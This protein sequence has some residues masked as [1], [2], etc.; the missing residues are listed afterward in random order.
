[1]SNFCESAYKALKDAFLCGES[2][3]GKEARMRFGIAENTFNRHI[4]HYKKDGIAFRDEWCRDGKK[5]FKR[6]WAVI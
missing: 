5:K 4:H 3:T 1:M 2:F 6:H